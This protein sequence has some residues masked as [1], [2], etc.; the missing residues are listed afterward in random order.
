[1][2][3]LEAHCCRPLPGPRALNPYSSAEELRRH[4]W[5]P[6][7]DR[8]QPPPPATPLP[9]PKYYPASPF[10]LYRDFDF[11][12]TKKDT[13]TV[14][15]CPLCKLDFDWLRWRHRCRVCAGCFCDDCCPKS[16]DVA[17]G[18]KDCR[19][20]DMCARA[21]LG[22]MRKPI[23]KCA[24]H[25]NGC[26]CD[27]YNG[28]PGEFCSI[29]CKT[30]RGT[31]TQRTHIFQLPPE[32]ARA[33]EDMRKAHDAMDAY[34]AKYGAAAAKAG[35][36]ASAAVV[37]ARVQ[38]LSKAQQ[39]PPS[40]NDATLTNNTAR[41]QAEDSFAARAQAERDRENDRRREEELKRQRE[42]EDNQYQQRRGQEDM[43]R[44][45]ADQERER[46]ER[47]R[48]YADRER[49]RAEQDR[50]RNNNW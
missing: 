17:E 4:R 14:T 39:R 48:E 15:R 20:C 38:A 9:P 41:L 12:Q 40:S 25:K 49:E 21:K 1:V 23:A 26:Q 36:A 37:A 13:E 10:S 29:Q 35:A 19:V 24:N 46:A 3:R 50:R 43:L 30:G 34:V 16:N 7:E 18:V 31:C 27:S 22:I 42:Y 11:E 28:W 45:Y 8:E 44:R 6:L 47:Q 5:R 2:T 32:A 33:A